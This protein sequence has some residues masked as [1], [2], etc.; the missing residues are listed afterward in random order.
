VKK[1][2]KTQGIEIK[3]HEMAASDMHGRIGKKHS[4]Y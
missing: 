2:M 3:A 1:A 4:K